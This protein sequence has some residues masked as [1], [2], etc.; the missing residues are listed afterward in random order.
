MKITPAW[1]HH[2]AQSQLG[3]KTCWKSCLRMSYIYEETFWA[4]VNPFGAWVVEVEQDCY[5]FPWR[6]CPFCGA[7][8]FDPALQNRFMFPGDAVTFFWFAVRSV[9]FSICFEV[10][11][12]A[13]WG[14]ILFLILQGVFHF[15][16]YKQ[17]KSILCHLHDEAKTCLHAKRSVP[18]DALFFAEIILYGHWP[19]WGFV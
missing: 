10:L 8:A 16:W 14:C 2:R 17:A 15:H 13:F 19:R 3:P 18:S 6:S 11:P 5:M 9:Y 12:L 7:T 4:V 1:R